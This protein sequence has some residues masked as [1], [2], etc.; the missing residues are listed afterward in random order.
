MSVRRQRLMAAGVAAALAVS[1]AACASSKRAENSGTSTGGAAASAP[2]SAPATGTSSSGIGGSTNAGTGS[3]TASSASSSA[4][5]AGNSNAVFTFGA[6]GAPAMFDP[7]YATDGESFR[8]VRQMMEGLVSFK[9]GTA[10]IQPALAQ[11]WTT[12]KDGLTWNFKVRPNV[13]FSDGST[14]DAAAICYNLDRMYSQTGAGAVQAQY[15]S[16]NMGGFKGQK[17]KG[18]KAIPSL[19]KS[20]TPS[21]D[22]AVV[23]ISA[24]TSKFPALLGLPSFSIQSPKALKQYDANN[25]QASGDAFIYPAYATAHPTGTGPM[26]FGSYDKANG[27]ITLV[28][29]DSYWGTKATISALIFKII[30][31]ETARKQAL[32]AGTIDG[33]DLPN[34]ADWDSLKQNYN[35]LIR[36]AFNNLYLGIDMK[37]NKAL[38][39]LRVRQAIAYAM[40]RKD[41]VASQLPEGAEVAL[42]Y[43]PKT[44]TGWTDQVQ[45]YPYNP[46]K[47]KQLL[48]AA[49]ATNLT[50]NFWWPTEVSR[51]YMPDPKSVFTAFSA[52]L[53][54]VGIKLNVTSKPWNG[55]YLDGVEANKPDLFFL[56]W[57]G[58]YNTPDNFLS[59]S[60][61]L[62]SPAN[63]FDTGAAPWGKKLA[64]DLAAA[65]SQPDATKRNAMYVQ[66]NKDLLGKYLPAIPISS[67][68]PALV[69]AKNVTGVVASPLTDEDYAH[70][71]IGKK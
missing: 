1:L 69:L 4:A 8:P 64:A 56:G 21:G 70:V 35:L 71:I 33:Y 14:M 32:Q 18:G 61:A 17:D 53:Q 7:L 15:W 25:V 19:Y 44:V 68:P 42:E 48:Q 55:G 13:T 60:L 10:D 5:P 57:T 41:F 26:K 47:A 36:P 63:R 46:G 31:D 28:R 2:A 39:D 58:D 22:T 43:Y 66:L 9:P 59:G 29:N 65:D 24:Y 6:A 38:Q 52:D 45:Q 40:N 30:P 62:Q 11:S 67:S 49:G 34:P 37:N 54:A 27:V 20:C 23:K 16:D 12:S 50:L 3:S 51:P